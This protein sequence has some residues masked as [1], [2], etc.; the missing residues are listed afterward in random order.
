M[1]LLENL[2]AAPVRNTVPIVP[3]VPPPGQPIPVTGT[4]QEVPE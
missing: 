1:T 3:I 4:A 2:C